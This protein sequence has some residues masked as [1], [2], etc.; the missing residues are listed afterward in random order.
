MS[1]QSD[2]IWM[3]GAHKNDTGKYM[4]VEMTRQ[5]KFKIMSI[6]G[7]VIGERNSDHRSEMWPICRMAA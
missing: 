1:V 7:H 6:T 5:A 3:L 4:G 2:V